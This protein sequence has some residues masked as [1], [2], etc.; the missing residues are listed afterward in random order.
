MWTMR[1]DCEC[2]GLPD[3]LSLVLFHRSESLD[4][5]HSF[6]GGIEDP[7]RAEPLICSIPEWSVR[8][9]EGTNFPNEY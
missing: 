1:P 7:A 9:L 3:L 4:S 6:C 8:H 2:V 5:R